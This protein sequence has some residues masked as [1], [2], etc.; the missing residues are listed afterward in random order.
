MEEL[1]GLELSRSWWCGEPRL[2][3]QAVV[4][5][6][7]KGIGRSREIPKLR[8]SGIEDVGTMHMVG[9][10]PPLPGPVPY[11][12]NLTSPEL[13]GRELRPPLNSGAA[14]RSCRDQRPRLYMRT[15]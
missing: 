11:V 7:P 15:Q 9:L 8:C 4:R 1:C 2:L 10:L 12:T 6:S 14:D 3:R 13:G 5:S